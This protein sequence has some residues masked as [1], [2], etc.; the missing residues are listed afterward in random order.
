MS[1][2]LP[3][4]PTTN[5]EEVDLGQLFNAIGKLFDR[6][7]LFIKSIFKSI[8]SIFIYALKAV[9]DNIKLIGAVMIIAAMVGYFI[10]KSRPNVYSSTMVVRP[11]FDTKY[12]LVDNIDYFNALI[13]SKNHKTLSEIF[14]IDEEIAKEVVSF[15]VE[16]GPETENDQL[17]KY[18]NFK[19]SID[20]TIADRVSFKDFIDNRSI[21][22]GDLYEITVQ[23]TKSD[24]FRTL[25]EG[26][27]SSFANE[28]SSK[29][30]A[31]RDTL[32]AI[33]KA[34]IM[35]SIDQVQKLQNVYINVLEDDTKKETNYTLG[36]NLSLSP[37]KTGT[38]EFELLNE[39]IRLRK[40]LQKLDEQKLEEDVF[41]DIIS[42]FQQIGNKSINIMNRYS[43][44]FPVLAFILLCLVYLTVKLAKYVRNYEE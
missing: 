8:F 2:N 18:N 42:S 44:I 21:Y 9:F 40:Q 31:K 28:Y 13:S 17:V 10:E 24:I 19:K 33:Q 3:N 27:N 4:Q 35:A 16:I 41:F 30:M 1:N 5:S 37:E 7:Y 38:K 22:T 36:E 32:I 39:E 12:Q 11:Y 23:S 29:K 20:S 6:F 14:S 26:F 34:S 15:E 25:E 43:L